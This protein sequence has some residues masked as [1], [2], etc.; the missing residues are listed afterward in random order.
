MLYLTVMLTLTGW[1]SLVLFAAIYYTIPKLYNT[2]LYSI[3]LAN[4][5]FWMAVTGQIIFSISMWIAGVQQ[6]TMLNATN[7]DGSLHYSFVETLAELYP[8]WHIRILGGLIYFAS[9]LVFLYNIAKT[10][11]AG[12]P[13]AVAQKA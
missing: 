4:L 7:P 11:S 13:Q 9:L 8:Y 6:A 2:D 3:P 1:V 12:K 5:H 10:I